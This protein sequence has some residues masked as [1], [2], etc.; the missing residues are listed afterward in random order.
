MLFFKKRGN[1]ATAKTDI[2]KNMAK[3]LGQKI[4]D[5]PI[6]DVPN[7]HSFEGLTL[8][9]SAPI[10]HFDEENHQEIKTTALVS[11]ALPEIKIT[12]HGI[13]ALRRWDFSSGWLRSTYFQNVSGRNK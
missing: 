1:P 3:K 9:Y 6:K 13:L 8:T 2:C 11:M 10:L 4:N 5:V 7:D 12:G